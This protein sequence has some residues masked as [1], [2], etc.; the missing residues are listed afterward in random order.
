M[1]TSS[2][3]SPP[4]SVAGRAARAPVAL[5]LVLLMGAGSVVLW[6]G[7]PVGVIW[8][9]SQIVATQQQPGMGIYAA[10]AVVIPTLMWLC[11]RLLRRLD[12]VY[13]RVTGAERDEI[14]RPGWTRSMRGERTSNRRTT[15]LDVVMAVSVGLAIL[16]L[17]AWFALF[18][19][20]PLPS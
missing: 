5:A 8:G 4:K 16:A 15:I 20:S 14:Y 11:L 3:A 18:A 6:I 13:A 10:M 19:G 2:N 17:L 12:L 9:A 1:P 7:I